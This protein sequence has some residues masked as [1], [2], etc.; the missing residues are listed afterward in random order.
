MARRQRQSASRQRALNPALAEDGE[1]LADV[2]VDQRD[3]GV[4]K[5]HQKPGRLMKRRLVVDVHEGIVEVEPLAA[6]MHDEGNAELVEQR[7]APVGRARRRDVDGVDL[8]VGD[9]AAIGGFL[10]VGVGR[11]ENKVE[12]VPARIVPKAGEEFDEVRIDVDRGAG[13]KHVSDIAWRLGY[14]SDV[15]EPKRR[16]TEIRNWIERLVLPWMSKRGRG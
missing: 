15:L 12:I 9:D 6:A 3:P 16:L 2:A 5:L 10:V 11:R 7:D 13:R 14:N 8:L 1:G 4:P